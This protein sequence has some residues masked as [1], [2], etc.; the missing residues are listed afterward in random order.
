MF[1]ANAPLFRPASVLLRGLLPVSISQDELEVAF[2]V[3]SAVLKWNDVVGVLCLAGH[4][5]SASDSA[6]ATLSKEKAVDD[7][8][9]R[10]AV[11]SLPHPFIDGA[12]G[13]LELSHCAPESA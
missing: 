1:Q 9:G 4:H 7:R 12:A 3:V 13:E 11:G 2:R 5:F 8:L 6:A 10:L